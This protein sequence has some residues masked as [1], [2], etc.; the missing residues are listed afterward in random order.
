MVGNTR[1]LPPLSLRVPA[2][3]PPS[4]IGGSHTQSGSSKGLRFLD[5]LGFWDRKKDEGC[6]E[7]E[8]DIMGKLWRGKELGL[9]CSYKIG[10]MVTC[11]F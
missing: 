11:W 9:F 2:S 8:L 4:L 5:G 10:V 3:C 6:H 1:T 7:M